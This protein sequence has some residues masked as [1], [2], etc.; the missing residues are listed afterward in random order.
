MVL[1]R[2]C[3][4]DL[5]NNSLQTIMR[6]LVYS[7]HNP[8]LLSKLAKRMYL[9]RSV[10]LTH[11]ECIA[12]STIVLQQIS[13]SNR[14]ISL[15]KPAYHSA[16][17]LVVFPDTQQRL[18]A[19]LIDAVSVLGT[20]FLRSFESCW[21]RQ[22]TKA[23]RTELFSLLRDLLHPDAP[24]SSREVLV[25]GAMPQKREAVALVCVYAAYLVGAND[26]AYRRGFELLYLAHTMLEE[27]RAADAAARRFAADYADEDEN[28]DGDGDGDED[29]GDG[30]RED[31]G[32]HSPWEEDEDEGALRV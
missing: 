23:G 2:R 21:A 28:G 32:D 10:Y 6:F 9:D 7:K 11:I 31:F 27:G 29:G 16:N 17:Y 5:E 12:L 13:G 22:R 25:R 19:L 20:G 18:S 30:S 14:C 1:M 8:D 26:G 24:S 4:V 15:A 3:G